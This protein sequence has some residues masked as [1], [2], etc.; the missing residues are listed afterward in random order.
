[1][2]LCLPVGDILDWDLKGLPKLLYTQVVD[3]NERIHEVT[4]FS[5]A[6]IAK[7]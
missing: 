4:V 6:R 1:M 2:V 3:L 5:L 7:I